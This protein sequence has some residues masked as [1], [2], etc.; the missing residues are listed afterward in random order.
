MGSGWTEMAEAAEAALA[1]A[2]SFA[3]QYLKPEF[4]SPETITGLEGTIATVAARQDD[5]TS[6]IETMID[7]FRLD[8]LRGDA[9]AHGLTLRKA[10]VFLTMLGQVER[11][12]VLDAIGAR[13]REIEL[14]ETYLDGGRSQRQIVA[15]LESANADLQAFVHGEPAEGPGA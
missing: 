8:E 5:L 3:D 13:L 15:D 4:F 14:R 9:G 10:G 2:K 1:G 6:R 12:A 11:G 7:Q